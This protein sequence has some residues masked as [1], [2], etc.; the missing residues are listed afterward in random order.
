MQYRL[1][2]LFVFA[3][4]LGG[5]QSC[6]EP[7]PKI[8][9]LFTVSSN[10]ATAFPDSGSSTDGSLRYEVDRRQLAACTGFTSYRVRETGTKREFGLDA[11]LVRRD[12]LFE[13]TI[14]HQDLPAA[15]WGR[16]RSSGLANNLLATL[17]RSASADYAIRAV[18]ADTTLGWN[19]AVCASPLIARDAGRQLP[20]R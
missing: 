11:M 2:T 6:P 5:A 18:M 3:A 12:S 19:S 10:I 7:L 16:E 13:V 14:V 4:T 17:F 9:T 1:R 8:T 15:F 20:S